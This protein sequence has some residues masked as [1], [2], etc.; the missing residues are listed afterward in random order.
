M[1][2]P[3]SLTASGA[4]A[5]TRQRMIRLQRRPGELASSPGRLPSEAS[6]VLQRGQTRVRLVKLPGMD[7]PA[8]LVDEDALARVPD[9]NVP[10][11]GEW[12]IHRHQAGHSN[13]TFFLQRGERRVSFCAGPRWEPSFRPR[14]TSVASTGCSRPCQTT[15]VP[16]AEDDP[17]MHGRLGHR[18]ALLP[19]G[20]GRRS[21]RS[22]RELPELFAEEHRRKLGEE[23]VDALVELHSVDPAACGLDGFGK[24]AGYLERQLRRW[25]GQLELTL[26]AHASAAGSRARRETGCAENLP[27]SGPTTLVHGDYKLD[28]V[29]F[30]NDVTAPDSC[31]SSIGRCRRSAIRSPTSVG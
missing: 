8:L 28:N 4:Q 17:R 1:P 12:T 26:A 2:S 13:E 3:C 29:M 19:D 31:R 7:P 6:P 21:R 10:S 5:G 20:A 25:R 9:E 24:P 16:S 23:L 15:S 14:T 27:E 30:A 11:E 18:R 22:A